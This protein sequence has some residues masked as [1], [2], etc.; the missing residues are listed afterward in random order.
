MN[1]IDE[2]IQTYNL[3]KRYIFRVFFFNFTLPVESVWKN[4]ESS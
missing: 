4:V 1:I 3:Q 2:T